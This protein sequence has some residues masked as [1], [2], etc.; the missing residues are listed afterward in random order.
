[1]VSRKGR[2]L[3]ALARLG[4]G[5]LGLIAL[6]NCLAFAQG[7]TAAL[8]GVVRDG[9]G[10]VV[11]K[12]TITVKH[13]ETGLTRTVETNGDGSYKVPS[14]PVGSYEL[15]VEKSGFKQLRRGT[16]LSV[17]V[18]AEVDLTLE[19]G[20]VVQQATVTEQP[21]LVNTSAKCH[22][23]VDHRSTGKGPAAERAQL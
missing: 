5:I 12:A 13:I 2:R 22:F 19:V 15:T 1:M 23:R 20:N 9:S 3:H 7:F 10:A 17:A 18:E 8:S 16:N 11:P 4:L 21:P 6:G 14:L